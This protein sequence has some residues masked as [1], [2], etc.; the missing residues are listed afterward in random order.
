VA[1]LLVNAGLGFYE[2]AEAKGWA[3]CEA[4]FEL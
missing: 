4:V 3:G 2:E 1:D